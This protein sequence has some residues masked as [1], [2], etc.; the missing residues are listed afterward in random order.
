MNKKASGLFAI[1]AML[2]G[3]NA[4]AEE[5]PRHGFYVAA[6]VGQAEYEYSKSRGIVVLIDSPFGGGTF[7]ALPDDIAVD[8]DDWS[9]RGTLGYRINRY[10]AAELSYVDF[11]EADVTERYA[12]EEPPSPFF[13]DE[14]TRDYSGNVAGPIASVMGILPVGSRFEL[15]LRAGV[16]FAD[17]KVE[18]K[19]DTGSDSNTFG[20][21]V[22][23]GG[24][25]VEYRFTSRWSARLE[26]LR[27]DTIEK[28]LGAGSSELD[29]LSLSVAF[30]L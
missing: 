30:D 21:E 27:T 22:W 16:L 28:N 5:M 23:V 24:A 6:S 4:A 8:N 18:Q 10:I 20:S 12:F 2:F 7:L 13:P 15:F 19:F 14:I 1:S 25:G 29:D 17:H 3:F 26:Y 9:W 11:G